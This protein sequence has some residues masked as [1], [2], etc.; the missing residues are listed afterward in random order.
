MEVVVVYSGIALFVHST[1]LRRGDLSVNVKPLWTQ[2][3][4]ENN[5]RTFRL[6]EGLFKVTASGLRA[7]F[8]NYLKEF[9]HLAGHRTKNVI[10]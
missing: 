3:A 9:L 4:A 5:Q 1:M 6:C 8:S 2:R 7:S 10:Y